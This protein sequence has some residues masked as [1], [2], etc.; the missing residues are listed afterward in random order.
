MNELIIKQKVEAMIEY[1][2]IALKQFPKYE[3]Y[4]LAAEIRNTMLKILRL[5]VQ[6]HKKYHKKTSLTDLDIELDVLRAYVR[7][8]FN[9]HYINIPKYDN[10]S[11]V[12][13]EI[14]RILGGFIKS[15]E[16]NPK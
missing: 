1:G 8:A 15:V 6:V 5:V 11:K 9:L 10:W 13:D 7:L 3:K 12:N 16:Q 4:A 14:G 2:Y